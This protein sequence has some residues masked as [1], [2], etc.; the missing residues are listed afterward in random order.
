M[1]NQKIELSAAKRRV[2]WMRK[3]DIFT[4]H[5]LWEAVR[6]VELSPCECYWDYSDSFSKEQ[7]EKIEENGFKGE[8]EL[9]DNLYDNNWSYEEN[10]KET[11]IKEII[12]DLTVDSF[13][14]GALRKIHTTFLND[15]HE[16]TLEEILD[17]IKEDFSFHINDDEFID[18]IKEF[19]VWDLNTEQLFRNTSY[20]RVPWI[21]LDIEEFQELIQDEI[22]AF[23]EKHGYEDLVLHPDVYETFYFKMDDVI[24]STLDE[25][26]RRS[27]DINSQFS[28][29]NLV[30]NFEEINLYHKDIE[31]S[32]KLIIKDIATKTVTISTSAYDIEFEDDDEYL[33]GDYSDVFSMSVT[34]PS[35]EDKSK[36]KELMAIAVEIG[37]TD[38]DTEILCS[39]DNYVVV[40]SEF[41]QDYSYNTFGF[42][43]GSSQWMERKLT[44]RDIAYAKETRKQESFNGEIITINGYIQKKAIAA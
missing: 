13:K 41:I 34:T 23:E 7:L 18:D 6:E 15:E 42:D 10:M 39:V 4:V 25:L 40:Q 20:Q 26:V 38:G 16:W 44:I 37:S 33:D 43:A 2:K 28:D 35:E 5:T 19:Q 1:T 12:S 36:L 14:E 29:F 17:E 11:Q 30:I 9:F 21:T 32:Q 22:T 27:E 24:P 31:D 8:E 3:S